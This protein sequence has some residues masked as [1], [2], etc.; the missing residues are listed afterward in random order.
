MWDV[1]LPYVHT[2]GIDR[3]SYHHMQG[4]GG[5]GEVTTEVLSR[6]FPQDWVREYIGEQL[7]LVDPIPDLAAR[8]TRPFKWSEVASLAKITKPEQ[9]FLNRLAKQNL[10]DGLALQVFGPSMRNGYVG[11]GFTPEAT[12]LSSWQVH[13]LQFAAQFA[14]LRYCELVPLRDQKALTQ[15]EREVLSWIAR[16]KSNSVIA[17]ILGVSPH[18]VDTLV[19]RIYGKLDVSDRTT[20]A[21]RGVGAGLISLDGRNVA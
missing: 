18:T 10:G 1:V 9:A 16:G 21:I 4:I 8:A 19:R 5:A 3:V 11:L 2:F 17:D 12:A 14:H 7:Y 15:R 20:A 6:G 13:E